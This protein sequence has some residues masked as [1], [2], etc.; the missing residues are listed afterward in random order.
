MSSKRQ[1]NRIA[2]A[3]T[4]VK[5]L[6]GHSEAAIRAELTRR[7]NEAE[8]KR[9]LKDAQLNLSLR[10]SKVR[11]KLKPHNPNKHGIQRQKHK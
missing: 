6:D 10:M 4:R 5:E 9:Q 7:A 8:A 2:L 11:T 3:R 1:H